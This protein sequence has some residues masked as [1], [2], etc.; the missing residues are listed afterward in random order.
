MKCN[1]HGKE[2]EHTCVWCGS[3]ICELCIGKKEGNKV[4]CSRCVESIGDFKKARIPKTEKKAEYEEHE[5][6]KPRM[7]DGYLVID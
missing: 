4:F 5:T 6:K 2:L 7:E 3:K 1:Y